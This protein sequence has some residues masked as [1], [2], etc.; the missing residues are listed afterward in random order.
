[1]KNMSKTNKERLIKMNLQTFAA[2]DGLTVANDLGEVRSIDFVNLF[3][4]SIEELL[5]VLG[6]TRRM[7]LSGDE[8]IQTYKY[9]TTMAADNAVGEGE[10]IPLSK[11]KK[12]KGPAYQVPLHKYRK[13]VSGESIR[14]VGSD[15]AINETDEKILEEI[16][17]AIKGQFFKYLASNPTKQ[18]VEGFQAALSM[19]WAKTKE[20]FKGNVSIISMVNATDVAKYLGQAPIQSGP[21]TA[22]GF[23]LLT[24][25]LSQ[26]VLVFDNIPQGKIYTTAV[27]NIVLANADVSSSDFASEFELTTDQTGLIGVTHDTV[28][29]NLTKE[30]IAVE[31]VQLFAEIQNGV[32]ETTITEPVTGGTGGGEG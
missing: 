10:L 5:Q 18:D 30:T 17:E 21:S 2:E 14:R 15:A 22:Y 28:K 27:N 9:E 12:V 6:V 20:F 7:T 19:G 25:F 11:V 24:G 4:Y 16:Q 23:T 31:G 8:K 29:N 1:M 3:G 13:S 32:I 26:T